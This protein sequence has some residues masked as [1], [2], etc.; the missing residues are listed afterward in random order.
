MLG[1]ILSLLAIVA[2][3]YLIIKRVHAAAALLVVG[4]ALLILAAIL[5]YS[6]NTD[7]T[8]DPTGNAFL[9]QM[10]IVEQI[11]KSRFSGVGLSIM[12][13]F[14][15]VAYMRHIG[16]DAK[17]VVV[18][19]RPLKA[20]HGSYWMV[21]LGFI[22]G[23][24]LSLV[25][26]S[27]AAL[28]LL[29]IATLLPALVAAGMTP[30]TVGAIVVTSSSIMPTPLE[31]GLIRG[32]ELVNMPI[33][34]Y[35]FSHVAKATVPT[36]LIVAFV[37]MWWQHRCDRQDAKKKVA[38]GEVGA[39]G[40]ES[41]AATEDALRRAA[42]LPG[43]Y[44]IL[45]LLPLL[46]IVITATLKR[47]DVLKF[48]AGILPATIISLVITLV[49][50]MVRTRSINDSISSLEN[51]FKGLGEGAAG[52]V[53]LLIA[54]GVLVEGVTQMGVITRLTEATQGS[55]GAATVIIIVFAL[56]TAAL[57]ILTGSG[58]APYFAFAEFAPSLAATGVLPVR[59]LN[60]IW[61]TS[62]LMRQ[63]SPVSAAVLIVSGA[64]KVSPFQ[65]VKRAAVPMAVG[66]VVNIV[67]SFLLIHV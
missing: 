10:L 28:S 36:I 61:G 63:A 57:A 60:A 33:S 59:F 4:L 29:L 58:V 22:V 67:L 34:D 13:L 11:F 40:A 49:I 19:S 25:V 54:A 50:E 31:A 26:P 43:F 52:V 38:S 20:F 44:S 41:N 6:G 8:I 9:D 16:A 55:H 47:F 32:A 35:V 53:S 15:F 3:G 12:I 14:G 45:P 27:A 46:I 56:S 2:A 42:G 39:V 21:P 62:N 5:G 1:I 30:L 37:H 66:M 51:F 23:N 18:L 24:I 17:T 65:L 7:Q 48:E 64:I